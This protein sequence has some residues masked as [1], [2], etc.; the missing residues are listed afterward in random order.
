MEHFERLAEIFGKNRLCEMSSVDAKW[1]D[2]SFATSKWNILK[3]WQ[4]SM[5]ISHGFFENQPKKICSH[6]NEKASNGRFVNLRSSKITATKQK[7]MRKRKSEEKERWRREKS[8]GCTLSFYNDY[9]GDSFG[10]EKLLD[11]KGPFGG[12]VF[13]FP[14]TYIAPRSIFSHPR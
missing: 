4:N 1:S 9:F 12:N 8:N 10:P 7:E 5:Q 14:V 13:K 6:L 11:G 3:R 2:K